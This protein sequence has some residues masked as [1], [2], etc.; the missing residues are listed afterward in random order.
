MGVEGYRGWGLEK[1]FDEAVGGTC[2]VEDVGRILVRETMEHVAVGRTVE[3][4]SF[5][6]A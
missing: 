6:W 5:H 3:E 1:E 2:D 4:D